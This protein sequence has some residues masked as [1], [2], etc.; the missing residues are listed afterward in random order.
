MRKKGIP[1]PQYK[2]RSGIYKISC[3]STGDT[4][5]GKSKN[6][7][8]RWHHHKHDLKLG[9]HANPLLQ[10]LYD[11][12]GPDSLLMELVELVDDHE[13]LEAREVYW[14]KL[15]EPSINRVNTRLCQKDVEEIKSS[16]LS[17]EELSVRYCTTVKYL[18]EILRGG[19]WG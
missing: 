14:T 3:S 19:R 15:T 8:Q 9:D 17:L 16:S 12:C 6:L 18:R 10:G 7:H 5:I 4:Y 11:S 1:G 2:R 13:L